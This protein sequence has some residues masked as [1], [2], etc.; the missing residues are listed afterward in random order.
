MQ[1]HSQGSG[2]HLPSRLG[3]LVSWGHL[4]H[5]QGLLSPAGLSHVLGPWV[6][7]QGCLGLRV[8]RIPWPLTAGG[9]RGGSC[10]LNTI[11]FFC[12]GC[13]QMKCPWVQTSCWPLSVFL[14]G[15]ER[16]PPESQG[17]AQP[18]VAVLVALSSVVIAGAGCWEAHA[19]G[20]TRCIQDPYGDKACTRVC[21]QAD[22]ASRLVITPQGP[23]S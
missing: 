13:Q 14:P 20:A 11:S 12:R 23:E 4:A 19:S 9:R 2:A 21:L 17:A 1:G 3:E 5:R 7:P 15:H 18:A 16:F 8:P 22:G 10:R 6:H